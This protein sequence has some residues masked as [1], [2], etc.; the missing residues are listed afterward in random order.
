MNILLIQPKNFIERTFPL[1]LSYIATILKRGYDVYGFDATIEDFSKLRKILVKNNI[2]IV[3]VG[4]LST[5]IDS[6]SVDF[7]RS[8]EIA[9]FIKKVNKDIK[10]IFAGA[11]ATMISERLK[12]NEL[13]DYIISGEPESVILDLINKIKNK[14]NIPKIISS[15]KIDNLDNIEFPVRN[16]FNLNLYNSGMISKA[17]PY[18]SIMA[19]KGCNY[20]C[21]YCHSPGLFGKQRRRSAKNIVDEIEFLI[22]E[23]RIKCILI[24]DDNFTMDRMHVINFCNE[25]KRRRLKFVWECANG[26]RPENLDYDILKLMKSAGCSKI[27][28]GIESSNKHILKKIGRNSNLS[29]VRKVINYA[30]KSGIDVCGYFMIGFPDESEDTI[31]DTINFACNLNLDYA[32]FS[33]LYPLPGS[34]IYKQ[35]PELSKQ[36][37]DKRI[38]EKLRKKAYL[39]FYLRPKKIFMLIMESFKEP[40]NFR[41]YFNK[42]KTYF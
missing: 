13:I 31:K 16:L 42:I 17:H 36:V 2:R 18:T 9:G 21:S 22:K 34:R 35:W 30:K 28:L 20:N 1:G 23:H 41:I 7:K 19:S 14:K 15:K 26:L 6:M 40:H 32:H 5:F 27:S 8:L 3:L 38:L 10:I 24:E 25:L 39:K 11:Y 37:L 33:V 4:S 29:T 12:K